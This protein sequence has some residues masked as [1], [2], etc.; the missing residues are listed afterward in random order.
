MA[1]FEE[2]SKNTVYGYARVSSKE[3]ANNSSLESQK[4]ELIRQGVGKKIFLLKLAL[5][6]IQ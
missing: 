4:E 1:H 6:R 3:Q 2:I 5:L